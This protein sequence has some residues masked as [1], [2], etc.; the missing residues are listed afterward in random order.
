M[1]A[2]EVSSLFVLGIVGSIG[3]GK[4]TVA[5][6]LAEHGATWI[7]ADRIAKS[8]LDD[9]EVKSSLIGHFG[10]GITDEDGHLDRSVL[11]SRVFGD[12]DEKRAGLD[13]LESLVHPRV[14]T[15]IHR[16]LHHFESTKA[17]SVAL[18][19]VPLLF[20]SGWHYL[21]DSIWCVDAPR[22]ARIAR[23][24]MRNWDA[25]E[26]LNREA[27]QLDSLT[28]RR[29]SNRII[30]NDSTLDRLHDIVRRLFSEI[31][32]D[33]TQSDASDRHCEPN[34]A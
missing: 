4:S 17:P 32:A 18:L 15:E 22:D 27:N 30:E 25:Q 24:K 8:L 9:R 33:Q 29:L 14:R 28:K 11:A 2:K 7:D 20:E 1:G 12:D 10:G 23:V 6:S 3:A 19:D 21:C 5:A 26:L 13:Y 31:L 16:I 34:Q